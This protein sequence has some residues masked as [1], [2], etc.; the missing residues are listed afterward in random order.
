M[1]WDGIIE[2]GERGEGGERRDERNAG[3][4]NLETGHAGIDIGTIRVVLLE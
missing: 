3:G 2:A 1:G 4:R